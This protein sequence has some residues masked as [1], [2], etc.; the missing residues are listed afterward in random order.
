MSIICW[1]VHRVQNPDFIARRV[2]LYLPLL[3]NVPQGDMGHHLEYQNQCNVCLVQ[4]VD[5]LLLTALLRMSIVWEDV[6]QEDTRLK[7]DSML[8]KNAKANA[9]PENTPQTP[10]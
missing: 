4:Q 6:Q 1:N 8:P 9:L 5:F 10:D 2:Q 7:L 3:I